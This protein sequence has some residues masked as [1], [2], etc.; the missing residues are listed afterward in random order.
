[1]AA[2]RLELSTFKPGHNREDRVAA[3]EAL[4]LPAATWPTALS[5]AVDIDRIGD[6]FNITA[7]VATESE[8]ECAR[9]LRGFRLPLD[10]TVHLY[11]D[12]V[13][14]RGR[15][16]D[17]LGADDELVFHDGRHVDLD[18]GVREA[19]LLARPMVPLCRP[20]C[21]G[22]CSRCGADWNEGP[23][24]HVPAPGPA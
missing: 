5:L 22:L 18:G 14:A 7:R 17:D 13:G 16:E 10:F 20:D 3:P 23:C 1:M 11:A 15:G 6:Q 9:C 19:A 2:L 21:R 24:P 4:E 8:E 12:R